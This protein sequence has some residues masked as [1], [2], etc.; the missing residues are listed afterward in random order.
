VPF[1]LTSREPPDDLVPIEFQTIEFEAEFSFPVPNVVIQLGVFQ[2][3]TALGNGGEAIVLVVGIP[4]ALTIRLQQGNGPTQ[5]R[6]IALANSLHFS[7]KKHPQRKT[8]PP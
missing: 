7:R 1:S 4:E 8:E 2:H 3:M 6:A 5:F